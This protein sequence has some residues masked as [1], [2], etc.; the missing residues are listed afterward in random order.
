[1]QTCCMP[2]LKCYGGSSSRL[3]W[4]T[5]E[6]RQKLC[7]NGC[8]MTLLCDIGLSD[9]TLLLLTEPSSLNNDDVVYISEMIIKSNKIKRDFFNFHLHSLQ[10]S[11]TNV[12]LSHS[13]SICVNSDWISKH[14]HN[15]IECKAA[16]VWFMIVNKSQC[17]DGSLEI[18]LNKQVDRLSG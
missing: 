10:K 6:K 7:R 3:S 12:W 14:F 9:D 2:V 1:M 18:M 15:S 5:F 16:S 17:R 13:S 8:M 4:K 11:W